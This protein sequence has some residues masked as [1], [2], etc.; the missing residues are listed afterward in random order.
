MRIKIEFSCDEAETSDLSVQGIQCLIGPLLVTQLMAVWVVT[1]RQQIN[2]L[3]LIWSS[4]LKTSKSGDIQ[5][6]Q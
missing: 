1:K 3:L 2:D 6:A 4:K 5:W